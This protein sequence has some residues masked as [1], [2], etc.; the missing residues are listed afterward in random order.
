MARILIVEDE[1]VLADAMADGL[2]AAGHTAQTVY[3]GEK[4]LAAFR[5]FVPDIVLLDVRL[6]AVS[7]L[8]LLPVF[9]ADS[10]EL[11]VIILTAYGS[12]EVAVEAMKRGA[13]EFLTK[14]VDLDV[15]AVTVDKVLATS[16]A[17]RRLGQFEAAQQERLR[18]TQ[19]VG[20]CPAILQIQ[21]LVDRLAARSAASDAAPA[22]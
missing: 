22:T 18:H 17:K 7:G 3:A 8:D 10:P 5:E 12:V 13:S 1:T 4:A 14:P 16:A 9:K 21:E 11:P 6:G 2:R 20:Q 19:L 15:L